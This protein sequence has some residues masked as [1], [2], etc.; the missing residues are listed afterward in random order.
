[1]KDGSKKRGT[2][3]KC[4]SNYIDVIFDNGESYNKINY[5]NCI[6]K[7]IIGPVRKKK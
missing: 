4:Y 6:E 1:M 5:V 7:G 3:K 2:I